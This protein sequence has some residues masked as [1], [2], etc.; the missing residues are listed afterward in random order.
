[1][2]SHLIAIE[3]MLKNL[4]DYIA[5][6]S[7][8]HGEAETQGR[9][10]FDNE[11][12]ELMQQFNCLN[13]KQIS[14]A[15]ALANGASSTVD[16]AKTPQQFKLLSSL[17]KNTNT[18]GNN[19][20]KFKKLDDIGIEY[21]GDN[22]D[23]NRKDIT[24]FAEYADN[25]IT[26]CKKYSNSLNILSNILAKCLVA[27]YAHCPNINATGTSD[28]SFATHTITASAIAVCSAS[29]AA[30]CGKKFDEIA[31]DEKFAVVIGAEFSKIQDFIF[32]VT[33]SKAAKFVKGRSFLISVLAHIYCEHILRKLELPNTQI[34]YVG[35]GNFFI[36]LPNTLQNRTFLRENFS[37][38]NRNLV[39]K[40]GGKIYITHAELEISKNDLLT[41]SFSSTWTELR[42]KLSVNKT[43]KFSDLLDGG[44]ESEFLQHLMPQ[45]NVLLP[46]DACDVCKIEKHN[47]NDSSEDLKLCANC[48]SLKTLGENLREAK[49]LILDWQQNKN[50]DFSLSLDDNTV[51]SIYLMRNDKELDNMQS[52]S[53]EK[54]IY[55]LNNPEYFQKV[56]AWDKFQCKFMP[57]MMFYGGTHCP[58]SG[59]YNVRTFSELAG[60]TDDDTQSI[61]AKVL[62][63]KRYGVLKLDVDN[64]GTIFTSKESLAQLQSLSQSFELFF[65]YWLPKAI[66]SYTTANSQA[67][68]E[69]DDAN[70]KYYIIYSGG[71]DML[72]VGSW[73]ILP[74]IAAF[75]RDEFRNFACNSTG[76]TL[77][78]GMLFFAPKFPIKRAVELTDEAEA[79]AK[80]FKLKI[81]GSMNLEKDALCLFGQQIPWNDFPTLMAI[82]DQLREL[83]SPKSVDT[84]KVPRSV[85]NRLEHIAMLYRQHSRLISPKLAVNKDKQ[86]LQMANAAGTAKV[87]QDVIDNRADAAKTRVDTAANLPR[88]ISLD[89]FKTGIAKARWSWMLEYSL[90]A[91]YERCNA[92]FAT[93]NCENTKSDNNLK[94][95]YLPP[96][97]WLEAAINW[98]DWAT[99]K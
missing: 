3:L 29:Y 40:F 81:N 65:S 23:D 95:T 4:K 86:S 98:A 71:D 35:G 77:S 84:K 53:D 43:R 94:V 82:T 10:D 69:F 92:L 75:I 90:R 41:T 70:N 60:A 46:D 17:C 87:S 13:D 51:A 63:I 6:I 91:K 97:E 22:D 96:L 99:R 48:A 45:Q 59:K 14:L 32:S 54:I 18:G 15:N 38:I 27:N 37:I 61:P 50:A 24:N 42:K 67:D 28:I 58:M 11:L 21:I 56:D 16:T 64:L 9:A 49:F 68:T 12:Q 93:I 44:T 79:V 47:V 34:I 62:G 83:V 8:K 88:P 31:E 78:A 20:V 89:E 55:A 52:V 39:K 85:L 73:D 36:M 66:E 25:I 72:I 30:D 1:M 57:S 19:I 33:S 26:I 76:V 2:R 5:R 7:S 80:A 74:H